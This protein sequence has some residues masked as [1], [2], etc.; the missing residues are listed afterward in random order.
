MAKAEIVLGES[1]GGG[2]EP[3]I[4]ENSLSGFNASTFTYVTVPKKP[5]Y[6]CLMVYHTSGF[7]ITNEWYN[8]TTYQ[9][10][11]YNGTFNK[12]Q[13]TS[14]QIFDIQDD[15]VG[16]KAV[17]SSWGQPAYTICF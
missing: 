2:N 17:N 12:R 5:Q 3:A 8:D 15:K 16:F 13:T 6:V 10:F 7:S 1:G 14:N 9:T 11:V 4:I